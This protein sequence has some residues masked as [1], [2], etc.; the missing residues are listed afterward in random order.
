MREFLE[1][2]QFV[3]IF[4]H[5]LV[6]FALGFAVWLQRRRATGL[7]L[8]SSLIWLSASAFV[9]A[10][11]IWGY[12]FVPFQR[13]V[14]DPDIID[15]LIV[16]RALILVLAALLLIQFG[17]RLV[18]LSRRAKLAFTGLSF[19]VAV[20]IIGGFF[21]IAGAREWE[22]VAWENS[23]EA[24]TRYFLLFPGAALSAVAVWRQRDALASVGLPGMRPY[25]TAG[26]VGLGLLAVF[27]GL[28]VDPAPWVPA[29]ILNESGWFSVTGVPLAAV[30]TVIGLL[31]AGMAVK[32]LEIYEVETARQIAGLQKARLVAEERAR[33]GRDLHDGT[34][35]SIYAAGLQLEAAAMNI[36]DPGPKDEVRQVVGGLNRVIEGVR[37]YI[38]GL[39]ES[40]M[41]ASELATALR[42]QC[43]DFVSD[44]GHEVDFGAALLPDAG[45][46]PDEASQHLPQ[47]LREALSNSARH[48]GRCRSAVT[49]R[50][51]ADELELDIQDNGRGI[52]EQEAQESERGLRNMRERG[53]RLGGRLVVEGAPMGGT[54]VLLSVPLDSELP[55]ANDPLPSTQE[56]A[57]RS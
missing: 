17:L 38:R 5:G 54:R 22:V 36:D 19:A 39:S 55:A 44:T 28:I 15:G 2:N 57:R 7:R 42:G 45:P 34:I 33:F 40:P 4:T 26:A 47:I 14:L 8:T 35:Q 56:V 52:S 25:A 11:G 24:A 30:R 9:M 53:R 23:V 43:A 13:A 49:L 20:A 50:V 1:N 10:L 18:G 12:V 51:A 21:L 32:L 48:G 16:L 37:D 46:L 29:G 27:A 31:L 41:N 3:I 6:F